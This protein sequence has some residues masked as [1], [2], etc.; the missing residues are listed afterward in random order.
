[1]F[2]HDLKDSR[3]TGFLSFSAIDGRAMNA[4]F[5]IYKCS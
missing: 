3:N 2:L 1:M 4:A 5:F